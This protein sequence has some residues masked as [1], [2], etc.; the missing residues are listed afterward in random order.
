ADAVVEP[1]RYRARTG[2]H[3]LG[4]VADIVGFQ[5]V[6][7]G[8]LEIVEDFSRAQQ[9]LGRDAPPV[10]ADAAEVIALHDCSLEAEL[11]GPDRGD[12]AAGAGAD[13]ENI[14][15]RVSHSPATSAPTPIEL[16]P[17]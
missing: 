4:V 11:C 16:R 2:N 13:D 9:R 14:E 10:E 8:V 6:I 7:S 17:D 12:I 3:G 1:L 5:A 15:I